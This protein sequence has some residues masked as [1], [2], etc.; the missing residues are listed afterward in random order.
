[1]E[2]QVCHGVRSKIV[3][4]QFHQSK[5]GRAG[6]HKSLS[7]II[8]FFDELHSKQVTIKIDARSEIGDVQADMIYLCPDHVISAKKTKNRE[9]ENP[10]SIVLPLQFR[11]SGRD[12]LLVEL[13]EQPPFAT[14][15]KTDF[16]HGLFHGFSG[17]LSRADLAL[18]HL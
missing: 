9:G 7:W 6:T 5:N 3:I 4:R 17:L 13:L 18:Q 11:K 14:S 10:L 8:P 1:M 16:G 15:R 2:T 12:V